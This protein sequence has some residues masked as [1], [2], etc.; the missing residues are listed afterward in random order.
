MPREGTSASSARE[1]RAAATAAGV[2]SS[3][4]DSSASLTGREDEKRSASTAGR[5]FRTLD[6]LGAGSSAVAGFSLISSTSAVSIAHVRGGEGDVGPSDVNLSERRPLERAGDP[7][8]DELERR[9]KSRNRLRAE[10]HLPQEV[11]ERERALLVQ[12]RD[13]LLHL[14]AHR[15]SLVTDLERGRM[16]QAIPLGCLAERADQVEE[17][18]LQ[19]LPVGRRRR[20]GRRPG[21]ETGAERVDFVEGLRGALV[22]LVL[23]EAPR[24][25]FERTLL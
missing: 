20:R 22:A 5:I 8:A 10:L 15:E 11:E 12:A 16:G 19:C 17:R 3:A 24:E 13:Q 25:V 1:A 7:E 14:F 23:G 4:S 21:P 9:E 2:A 18:H 6:S